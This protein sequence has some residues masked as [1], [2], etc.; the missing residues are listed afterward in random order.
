MEDSEDDND[1]DTDRQRPRPR[2]R[3]AIPGTHPTRR[4]G[5]N[6]PPGLRVS[7]VEQLAEQVLFLLVPV[8]VRIPLVVAG[9]LVTRLL[10]TWLFKRRRARGL[11]WRWRRHAGQIGLRLC[12]LPSRRREVGT[13][14]DAVGSSAP[15]MRTGAPERDVAVVKLPGSLAARSRLT[16][17]KVR[18][19]DSSAAN[20][21]LTPPN[22]RMASIT[23]QA[24]TPGNSCLALRSAACRTPARSS[25]SMA[26][27]LTSPSGSSGFMA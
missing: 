22:R 17:P 15:S 23:S 7:E 18:S 10:V 16:E 1:N 6:D 27:I 4:P 11:R 19:S 5:G 20:H 2:G 12:M 25:G 13:R 24:R 21:R 8:V 9:L 3:F 26:S 14:N